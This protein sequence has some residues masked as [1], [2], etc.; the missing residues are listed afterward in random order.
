MGPEENQ[1]CPVWQLPSIGS[2]GLIPQKRVER[3]LPPG[4]GRTLPLG[5]MPP[6]SLAAL[7]PQLHGDLPACPSN[8]IPL[9]PRQL[10]HFS[11]ETPCQAGSST[12]VV[13]QPVTG[14]DSV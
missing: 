12:R 5:E 6:E 4:M 14:G 2:A 7:C 8:R 13:I 3:P 9:F 1:H 10:T 11:S